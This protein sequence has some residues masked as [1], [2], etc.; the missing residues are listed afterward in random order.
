MFTVFT[1]AYNRPNELRRLYDSL[2]RQTYKDFVWLI[3]DDSIDDAVSIAV[4]NMKEDGKISI[5]YYRQEHQGRYWAQ[6]KGFALV[7]TPYMV[8][9][10]DDDELTDDCLEVLAREWRKIEE[11]N[12]KE[13]GVVCGLCI[14]TNGKVISY[15]DESPYI[16]SDYIEMEW[17]QRHPSE[18]LISRKLDVINN[19]VIFGDDGNW[20]ADKISFV[21]ESVLWNRVARRYKSRYLNYPMRIYHTE[22]SERLSV[23]VFGEQKCIDYVYSNYV[24]LNELE[25]RLWENPKDVVKYLAEYVVCG[26]ALKYGIKTLASHLEA[27]SLKILA[28]LLYPVALPLGIYFRKKYFVSAVCK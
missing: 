16:D 20:L 2:L 5:D 24:L 22:S 25:N 18:H 23:P 28:G 21:R 27:S 14:N 13:I 10:D 12:K 17:T 9:I 4:K 11:E 6:K 19:V 15:H 7:K 1:T 8:D 26:S 3:V